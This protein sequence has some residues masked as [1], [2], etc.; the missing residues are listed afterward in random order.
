[1]TGEVQTTETEDKKDPNRLII[2]QAVEIIIDR[3]KQDDHLVFSSPNGLRF[4]H[5]RFSEYP[6]TTGAHIT[7][8]FKRS[9]E[10]K[11]YYPKIRAWFDDNDLEWKDRIINGD[12][13]MA[14]L[15]PLQSALIT[16]YANSVQKDLF[17]FED[18]KVGSMGSSE[19]S[20]KLMGYSNPVLFMLSVITFL[21]SM[22]YF[23]V[24]QFTKIFDIGPPSMQALDRTE[25]LLFVLF[26]SLIHI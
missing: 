23:I 1:M 15:L 20:M 25:I 17:G 16:D 3:Q 21:A 18:Y 4:L 11:P 10:M 2:D 8:M 24:Y 7:L 6:T 19:L 22:G 13:Y 14:T 5:L 12:R 26:L 9:P